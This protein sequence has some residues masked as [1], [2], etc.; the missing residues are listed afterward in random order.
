MKYALSAI[1]IAAAFT[2][3][4][5]AQKAKAAPQ[6]MCIYGSGDEAKPMSYDDFYKWATETPDFEELGTFFDMIN[7]KLTAADVIEAQSNEALRKAR[8]TFAR[9]AMRIGGDCM[10]KIADQQTTKNSEVARKVATAGVLYKLNIAL[11]N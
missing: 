11:A 2:L 5:E 10:T 6:P 7:D 8:R 3:P 9:M 1:L 4:A